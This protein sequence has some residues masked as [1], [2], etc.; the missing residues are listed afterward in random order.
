VITSL[1]FPLPMD[2]V[3]HRRE[4]ALTATIE[5]VRPIRRR[6]PLVAF[7]VDRTG[8]RHALPLPEF[9]Q[10]FEPTGVVAR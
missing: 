1:T 4:R 7:R 2:I 9:L 6:A 10:E 8:A 3:R 5:Q